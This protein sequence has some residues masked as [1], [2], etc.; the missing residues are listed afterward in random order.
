[1]TDVPDGPGGL[2]TGYLRHEF[3]VAQGDGPVM[4]TGVRLLV[5]AVGLAGGTAVD[6]LEVYVVPEPSSAC[7]ALIGLIAVGSRL[8]RRN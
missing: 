1:M 4:A 5:P 7:L 6:E 8:R 2:F 3:D